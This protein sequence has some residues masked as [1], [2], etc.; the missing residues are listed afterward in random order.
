[1]YP[2]DYGFNLAGVYVM[3][4]IV[5]IVLYPVCLWFAEAK[6]RRRGGWLSYL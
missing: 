1:L 4:L 6:Q 3:W 5:V 2:A